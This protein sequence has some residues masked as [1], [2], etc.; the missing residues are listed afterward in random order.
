M[1]NVLHKIEKGDLQHSEGKGHEQELFQSFHFVK[2]CLWYFSLLSF[3]Q[4]VNFIHENWN[5]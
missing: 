5:V 1:E 3:L 4:I 2:Y